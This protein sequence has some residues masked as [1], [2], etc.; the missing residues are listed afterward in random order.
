MRA[1]KAA[2]LCALTLSLP[3][4]VEASPVTWTLNASY[5]AGFD[6]LGTFVYDASLGAAGFGAIGVTLT[7]I[8]SGSSWLLNTLTQC[9]GAD[10]DGPNGFTFATSAVCDGPAVQVRGLPMTMTDAGGTISIAHADVSGQSVA[11]SAG[12]G[13]F[14]L[15]EAG[16]VITTAGAVPEPSALM[17]T[18]LA[19]AGLV[20]ARRQKA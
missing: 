12:C 7:E 4:V 2:A 11:C 14:G 16:S 10:Q 20:F 3:M 5:T 6:A 17:L 8:V 15:A 9:G 18:G 19:L 13:R 1:V